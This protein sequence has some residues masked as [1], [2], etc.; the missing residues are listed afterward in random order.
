MILHTTKTDASRFN[1]SDVIWDEWNT[2]RPLDARGVAS[3]LDH[4]PP[5]WD[6]PE[7]MAKLA[8]RELVRLKRYRP[9]LTANGLLIR[10]RP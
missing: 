1:V 10:A 6:V 4:S 3:H 8:T 2:V 9:P 7:S 5:R